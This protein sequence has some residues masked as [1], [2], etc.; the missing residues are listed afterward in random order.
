MRIAEYMQSGGAGAV[1]WGLQNDISLE[2]SLRNLAAAQEFKVT[3]DSE[4]LNSLI[5]FKRGGS[6]LP[7]WLSSNTKSTSQAVHQQGLRAR[8]TGGRPQEERPSPK[9]KAKAKGDKGKG[10]GKN[11]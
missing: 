9:G 6:L 2:S 8:G 10:G 3:G 7:E 4:A 1:A 5:M 11:S